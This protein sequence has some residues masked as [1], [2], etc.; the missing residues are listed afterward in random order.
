LSIDLLTL[1]A[2]VRIHKVIDA[3][4][5]ADEVEIFEED[6]LESDQNNPALDLSKNIEEMS[7]ELSNDEILKELDPIATI[8]TK[9][10]NET[11]KAS[12]PTLSQS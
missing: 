7:S 2:E 6:Q 9:E 8:A 3:I 1:T 5:S 12:P 11:E 4:G 10:I